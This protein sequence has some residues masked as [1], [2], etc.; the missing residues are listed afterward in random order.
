MLAAGCVYGC[1]EIED[2][3]GRIATNET[4]LGGAA[5]F[6]EP[7]TG[8]GSANNGGDGGAASLGA[9]G[10][11]PLECIVDLPLR[12]RPEGSPITAVAGNYAERSETTWAVIHNSEFITLRG[13]GYFALR[14]YVNFSQNP[15]EIVPPLIEKEDGTFLR[16]GGG[17]EAN[18]GDPLLGST[19]TRMGSLE[20]GLSYMADGVATPW[21]NEFYYLDGGVTIVNTELGGSYNLTVYAQ[22]YEEVTSSGWGVYDPG[23]VCDPEVQ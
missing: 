5:G 22:S 15:G 2:T 12:H 19:G 16:V 21:K 3:I 18:M 9:G 23:V 6:G 10:A 13:Q 8:D 1:S 14:W 4:S 17:G 11:E 20:E 7:G